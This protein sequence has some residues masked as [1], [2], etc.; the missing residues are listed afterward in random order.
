VS[1]LLSVGL[2]FLILSIAWRDLLICAQFIIEREEI[3]SKWCINRNK[4]LLMCNGQ[5]FLQKALKTSKE[6]E[7]KSTVNGRVDFAKFV[8]TKLPQIFNHFDF[9]INYK[10]YPFI[11]FKQIISQDFLLAI[12]HPPQVI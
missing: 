9:Y 1:R 7:K 12:F 8:C 11:Y 2:I 5:C 10:V 6:N 3:S 4:P